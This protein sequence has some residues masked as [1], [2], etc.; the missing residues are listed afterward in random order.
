[1]HQHPRRH[2]IRRPEPIREITVSLDA[3]YHRRPS[4]LSRE[5]KLRF[6]APQLV[7]VIRGLVTQRLAQF[8]HRHRD[9]IEP[10]LPDDRAWMRREHKSQFADPSVV[11]SQRVMMR[12]PRVETQAQPEP[13]VRCHVHVRLVTLRGAHAGELPVVRARRRE[14]G[15]GEGRG[16]VDRGGL[17]ARQVPVAVTVEHGVRWKGVGVGDEGGGGRR[18]CRG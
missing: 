1:M 5:R 11:G 7:G 9:A 14:R 12:P 17:V 8:V 6:K 18:G 2:R 16:E 15:A 13:D 4:K 3:V 10:D